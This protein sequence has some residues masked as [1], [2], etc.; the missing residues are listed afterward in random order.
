MTDMSIPKAFSEASGKQKP[1][2]EPPSL[3]VLSEDQVLEAFQITGTE[4]SAAGCW[5]TGSC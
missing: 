2:Y 4:I 1:A 5:W 3:K